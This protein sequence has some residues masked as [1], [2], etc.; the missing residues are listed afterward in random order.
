MLGVARNI[1]EEKRNARQIAAFSQLGSRLS[2]AVAVEESAHVI[3][4]IAS[5]LFGWDAG[6]I[7]TF[8]ADTNTIVHVLVFDT[9]DGRRQR[10]P[11]RK[12]LEPTPL[13][14]LVLKE[15]ARLINS[16]QDLQ[17][18][19]T[20]IPFGDVKRP[21]AC[22]MYVPIHSHG[23][24]VGLLSI[25]SYTPGAYSHGDLEVLQAL[26]DHCGNALRRIK[27]KDALCEAEANYRSI[28]ENASEGIFTSSLDGKILCINPAMARI[29]GYGSSDEMIAR[30]GVLGRDLYARPELRAELVRL[31]TDRGSVDGFEIETNCEDG[32]KIWGSL[33]ARIVRN[34]AGEVL[35]YQGTIQDITQ[36][37]RTQQRLADAME[38]NLTILGSSSVGIA[39]YRPSGQCIFANAAV[40]GIVGGTPEQLMLQNYLQ[41]PSWEKYGWL[42]VAEDA[43]SS[44]QAQLKELYFVSSFGREAWVECRMAPFTS[45]G[46]LHLLVLMIDIT[47]RKEIEEELRTLPGRIIEAQ[48]MERLRVA[49]ELH[50]SVNQLIASVQM[51][52]RRVEEKVAAAAPSAAE[53]LARCRDLLVRALEENRRIAHDLRPT[54]LDQLG[55]AA[56]CANFCREFGTRTNTKVRCRIARFEHRLPPLAE[57]N[58]FR[59]VQ[60]ALNNAHKH[61]QAKQVQLS[62]SLLSGSIHL[63]IRDEGCG[64]DPSR[65]NVKK[66]RR[67]GIGLTNIRERAAA[68]GG[69]CDIQSK[70]GQGTTITV[71][72]P[73][74]V[75]G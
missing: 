8:S 59:I 32:T 18:P 38:L 22:R 37:K 40:A 73:Y 29:H 4:E 5:D 44:R 16:G 63:R 7:D 54:D 15:G 68:L 48:E 75:A 49:R 58:L 72:V 55:F 52:L 1:S 19:A 13:M 31:L 70:P 17:P 47:K 66:G 46:E 45:S 25:Q 43:L 53:I 36:R 33:N 26:A 69:T 10:V 21:A 71:C 12:L 3:M 57:L 24:V 65:I 64:F 34:T 61:A 67:K 51:R 42:Q 41:I 2:G 23:A 6:Y 14:L 20:G 74:A 62:V 39:A 56:A 28:V 30:V 60:E 9:I 35:Y 27:L 11:S 50:D